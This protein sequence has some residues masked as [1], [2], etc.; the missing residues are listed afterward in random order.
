MAQ[1]P[2]RWWA[3]LISAAA[4]NLLTEAAPPTHLELAGR[5]DPTV[6]AVAEAFGRLIGRSIKVQ[7][8]PPF[9]AA[10]AFVDMGMSPTLG[11]LYVEMFEGRHA[12]RIVPEGPVTRGET[13]LS[14]L[15][16]AILPDTIGG[17]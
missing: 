15:L 8:A 7:R 14:D 5:E 17:S 2:S 13:P 6:E 12:G 4:A 9:A 3:P 1:D 10:Q 11:R 16:R